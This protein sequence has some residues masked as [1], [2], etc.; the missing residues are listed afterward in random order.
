MAAS[1]RQSSD[2]FES[3]EASRAC[4]ESFAERRRARGELSIRAPE[5]FQRLQKRYQ[6]SVRQ[7]GNGGAGNS[8]A[9][10]GHEAMKVAES[11]DANPR[12]AVNVFFNSKISRVITDICWPLAHFGG[13][14]TNCET[15]CAGLE[16]AMDKYSTFT[17]RL[18]QWVF[19][20]LP[21]REAQELAEYDWEI[22]RKFDEL[23]SDGL[24][25][26]GFK[27]SLVDLVVT[28]TDG[29]VDKCLEFLNLIA[30]WLQHSLPPY[31]TRDKI[32]P[33]VEDFVNATNTLKP[34]PKLPPRIV[35]D[36]IP[37]STMTPCPIGPQGLY[38]ELKANVSDAPMAIM[39]LATDEDPIELV[40]ATSSKILINK[41]ETRTNV[42][43]K[44]TLDNALCG[45][46]KRQGCWTFCLNAST[47]SIILVPNASISR[48]TKAL[49]GCFRA[50]DVGKRD[51]E[52]QTLVEGS[53]STGLASPEAYSS[54]Q[55]GD[56]ES[57]TSSL[58]TLFTSIPDHCSLSFGD[59][60]RA[61][62]RM[63]RMGT[64]MFTL[65]SSIVRGE[66]F[67][68]TLT[69]ALLQN[70]TSAGGPGAAAAVSST[71]EAVSTF[72]VSDNHWSDPEKEK[73]VD[74]HT[75]VFIL[76]T[77]AP[78]A[79]KGNAAQQRNA[80]LPQ[81]WFT[82]LNAANETKTIVFEPCS[83]M[84]ASAMG[85]DENSVDKRSE[86]NAKELQ[87]MEIYSI[88]IFT[89]HGVYLEVACNSTVP[90]QNSRPES[91]DTEA[92]DPEGS[93]GQD[94]NKL[95]INADAPM[96]SALLLK[97]LLLLQK[98]RQLETTAEPLPDIVV[99]SH[100]GS[101]KPVT[102]AE[103]LRTKVLRSRHDE[104]RARFLQV[105]G[106]VRNK[107]LDNKSRRQAVAHKQEPESTGDR[108]QEPAS[109][110]SELEK[111][112]D[113][114]T[115]FFHEMAVHRPNLNELDGGAAEVAEAVAEEQLLQQFGDI[116]DRD[117][118]LH[119][120]LD[121]EKW[122]T[123]TTKAMRRRA[124]TSTNLPRAMAPDS[125][126]GSC[127][128][129]GE[130]KCATRTFEDYENTAQYIERLMKDVTT[131]AT[132]QQQVED[133]AAAERKQAVMAQLVAS[134][135][136]TQ[137]RVNQP[138]TRERVC[139]IEQKRRHQW[140]QSQH[141]QV[142]SAVASA[143]RSDKPKRLAFVL[144]TQRFLVQE[145]SLPSNAIWE[146]PGCS[147]N[148][149]TMLPSG[150]LAAAGLVGPAG[151]T[152]PHAEKQQENSPRLRPQRPPQRPMTVSTAARPSDTTALRSAALSRARVRR[153]RSAHST[154]RGDSTPRRLEARRIT[155]DRDFQ[156]P[157]QHIW[158]A[159]QSIPD[160]PTPESHYCE[161]EGKNQ[162]DSPKGPAPADNLKRTGES[163]SLE[164]APGT[165][166]R[167]ASPT[168]LGTNGGLIEKS[169]TK[170]VAR[171]KRLKKKRL[172]DVRFHR[173][174]LELATISAEVQA[175]AEDEWKQAQGISGVEELGSVPVRPSR[176]L[177]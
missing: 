32:A 4:F 133:L 172:G 86:S 72:T 105:E 70:T 11:D 21:R 107:L 116:F 14:A 33:A 136:Y 28:C 71:V 134:W 111:R 142:Y 98:I 40:L 38:C 147:T 103:S 76:K 54:A 47:P 141:V 157:E 19:P 74:A 137:H 34:S 65:D 130:G 152:S 138:T 139:E 49:Y 128:Q 135:E 78:V 176:L 97:E 9:T 43:R 110:N 75:F 48:R 167:L 87:R 84:P 1:A 37:L 31:P 91:F 165:S 153:I 18:I 119:N 68:I 58:L 102:T 154:A 85:G 117:E 7:A 124:S 20:E 125:I 175:A 63:E 95:S 168:S 143:R 160:I 99:G 156:Q 52:L 144:P 51:M 73:R 114:L 53:E 155:S 66:P 173:R 118:G 62:Y 46:L 108:V 26:Q 8:T 177:L 15:E 120:A 126:S 79:L 6:L 127:D 35:W 82:A 146:V 24:S 150:P 2:E 57:S 170:P 64:R 109:P 45:E 123:D 149:T 23:G 90:G 104:R 140:M 27:R 164:I 112:V 13:G 83:K 60:S 161:M 67:S 36:T 80:T 42:Y 59:K 171:K 77:P 101:V 151:P 56:S 81:Q 129:T 131:H 25:L 22:D 100:V 169:T 106:A 16:L 69:A 132:R 29:S 55:N 5:G 89:L 148:Q 158:S 93:E 145:Q 92:Q 113:R 94:R 162:H 39:A 174:V 41:C 61:C 163:L 88:F 96:T 121:E 17:V 122:S 159:Q 50:F 3:G 10:G 44:V 166:V 12:G 115:T 30:R